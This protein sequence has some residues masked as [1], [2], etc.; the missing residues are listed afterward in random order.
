[1]RRREF[2]PVLRFIGSGAA[3]TVLTGALVSL[4]STVM[5][6]RLAYT[7]SFMLGIVLSVVLAGS[8]VFQSRFTTARVFAYVAMY[9][10]V[11]L[12]GLGALALADRWGIPHALNGGVV[13][14]TAPLGYLG[15]RLVFW[16]RE[17]RSGRALIKSERLPR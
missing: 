2:G 16:G 5:R 1:M 8:F 3:N 15:G 13:L 12:V 6:Y 17:N 7:I 14:I 9:L 11:Y 10:L 4:L